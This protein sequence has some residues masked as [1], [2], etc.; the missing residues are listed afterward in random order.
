MSLEL[1]WTSERVSWEIKLNEVSISVSWIMND[2]F[3]EMKG[4][5]LPI[6]MP[7]VD[8][9]NIQYLKHDQ[10][11]YYLARPLTHADIEWPSYRENPQGNIILAGDQFLILNIQLP[12]LNWGNPPSGSI[13]VL[14]STLWR[15]VISRKF[16][17]YL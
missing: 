3:L 5:L 13:K 7:I 14:E 16:V 4:R 11:A 2:S 8:A 1:Y 15:D 10:I 12:S 9:I 17:S 6:E